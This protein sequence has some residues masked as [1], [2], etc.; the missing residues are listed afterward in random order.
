MTKIRKIK[1]SAHKKPIKKKASKK[2][3]PK[4]RKKRSRSRSTSAKKKKI[5]KKKT[6]TKKKRAVPKIK[7]KKVSVPLDFKPLSTCNE[8]ISLVFKNK[9]LVSNKFWNMKRN[10]GKT[11][12]TWGRLGNKPT[13]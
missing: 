12:A 11:L 5:A 10:G 9:G 2:I 3:K 7:K 1:A 6:S 8:K 13:K 4:A